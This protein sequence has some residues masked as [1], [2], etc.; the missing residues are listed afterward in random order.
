MRRSQRR[1]RR[2]RRRRSGG[3]RPAGA[4]SVRGGAAQSGAQPRPMAL[5]RAGRHRQDGGGSHR[6]AARIDPAGLDRLGDAR[7]TSRS[8]YELVFG[9][10]VHACL[11]KTLAMA[12]ITEIFEALL[13]ARRGAR[14]QG[15]SGDRSTG[16]ACFPA[17]STSSSSLPS[18][19]KSRAWPP[20]WRRSPRRPT[21]TPGVTRS[22][23]LGAQPSPNLHDALREHQPHPFRFAQRHRSRRCNDTGAVFVAGSEWRRHVR[24]P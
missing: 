12:Q 1:S 14:Q 13:S 22:S 23:N 8:G 20:C 6:I 18:D 17:A 9:T 16:S 21:S 10:G 15:T 2:A 19:R 5:C 7:P 24:L 4:T 11:G 3:T